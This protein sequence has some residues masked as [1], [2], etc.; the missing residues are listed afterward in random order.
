MR[1]SAD[2]EGGIVF[3]GALF[4]DWKTKA[5]DDEEEDSI[6]LA[7]GLSKYAVWSNP[8]LSLARFMSSKDIMEEWDEEHDIGDSDGTEEDDIGATDTEVDDVAKED[9]D[10]DTED[11][12]NG[13]GESFE[14]SS[15]LSSKVDFNI[16]EEESFESNWG[17]AL[18]LLW[19]GWDRDE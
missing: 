7:N 1:V 3:K 8:P 12:S 2:D 19:C 18:S 4:R 14:G 17:C 5:E 16:E 15:L 13:D 11:I 6:E 10:A 9:D